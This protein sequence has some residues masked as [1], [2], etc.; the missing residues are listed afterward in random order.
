MQNA[1]PLRRRDRVM[2]IAPFSRDANPAG[3]VLNFE[4]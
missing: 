1:K 3:L 2:V 4:F